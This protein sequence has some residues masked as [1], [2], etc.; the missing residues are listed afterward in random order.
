M[1]SNNRSV[2]LLSAAARTADIT[3]SQFP[4]HL[5]RGI[6]IVVDVTADPATAAVTPK[7]RVKDENGDYNEVIWSA[8]AAIAA[9]GEFSYLI[10]PGATAADFDGTEAV[11]F[12]LPQE[13][14]LFMDAADGESLTYSVRGHFI[15]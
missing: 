12:P 7:I 6:L 2:T 3:T 10:Y 1:S 9:V 8:A 14:Q 11:G 5:Y 13:W 4:N 15:L